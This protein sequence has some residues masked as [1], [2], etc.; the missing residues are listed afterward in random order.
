TVKA[1]TLTTVLKYL[2]Y[3]ECFR[4]YDLRLLLAA[5]PALWLSALWRARSGG[6]VVLAGWL[7]T[8]A[9][10]ARTAFSLP[11]F[12]GD[13]I[14]PVVVATVLTVAPA[15]AA[16][17]EN[18]PR[19]PAAVPALTALLALLLVPNVPLYC[20]PGLAFETVAARLAGRHV[21]RAPVFNRSGIPADDLQRR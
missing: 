5:L 13:L 4:P 10:G 8:L 11:L 21:A 15:L 12:L 6:R 2:P 1:Q 17:C 7:A 16:W 19:W 3:Y 9:A 20:D 18:P 14:L